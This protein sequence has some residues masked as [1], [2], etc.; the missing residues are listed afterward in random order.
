VRALQGLHGIDYLAESAIA[1]K[2]SYV[3]GHV[4]NALIDVG[5]DCHN[6]DAAAYDWRLPPC[7]VTLEQHL[8][9][10]K[11]HRCVKISRLEDLDL[12]LDI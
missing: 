2:A 8:R 9:R 4:I 11:N 7:K 3:F 12:D 5:Y 1:K 10:M 6:L